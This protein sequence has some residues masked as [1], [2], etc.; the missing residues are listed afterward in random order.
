MTTLQTMGR[1]PGADR[2]IV[3]GGLTVAAT[4]LMTPL[5]MYVPW[6]SQGY[7]PT[8]AKGPVGLSAF[9]MNAPVVA[10]TGPS[11]A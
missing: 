1:F 2:M 11:G 9:L 3:A 6:K 7:G 8:P 10:R 5:M 4:L